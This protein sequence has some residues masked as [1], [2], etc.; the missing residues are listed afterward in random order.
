MGSLN[1]A[2]NDQGLAVPHFKVKTFSGRSAYIFLKAA[3]TSRD[4]APNQLLAAVLVDFSGCFI[5]YF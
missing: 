2:H 5:V 1:L 3:T 4:I